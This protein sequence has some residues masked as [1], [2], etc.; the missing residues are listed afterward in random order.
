M[1]SHELR[2]RT[3]S[4]LTGQHV[5][6]VL[7]T[8]LGVL[9]AAAEAAETL[10]R[11]ARHGR[12]QRRDRDDDEHDRKRDRD[13]DDDRDSHDRNRRHD[14]HESQPRENAAVQPEEDLHEPKQDAADG[15]NYILD[16]EPHAPGDAV[17]PVPGAPRADD[18]LTFVS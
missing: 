1:T 6:A 7:G 13:R 3:T 4:L 16:V 18:R 5:K 11:K 12:K 10:A 8:G 14:G 2:Q 9:W 15:G 17:T